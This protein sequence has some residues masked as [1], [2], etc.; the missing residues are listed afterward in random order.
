MIL[1][2]RI[3]G[4]RIPD[5]Q[6]AREATELA[7]ACSEPTIFNHVVRTYVF[8]ELAAQK[9]DVR[10]DLEV[11]YVASVLHDL[12]L[13]E[14]FAA[15]ERFE[16]D[17]ADAART[18]LLE[19]GVDVARTALIWDAIALHTTVGIADRKEPEVALVHLGTQLDVVGVTV[20][21]SQMHVR[22]LP[23][24]ALE[25]ILTVL[26]RLGIQQA[27]GDAVGRLLVKKPHTAYFTFATDIA[28]RHVPNFREPSY[29][30][31][32]KMGCFR[33]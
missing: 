23:S 24:E 5:S 29:Y 12:G 32:L 22:D 17:G 8:A 16:V 1:P 25:E 3:A 10:H 21:S 6:L 9:L 11:L 7:H 31:S 4:V 30:E 27:L 2:N 26:P 14:R 20:K 18:F 33:D 13:T 15:D 28:R 19:R